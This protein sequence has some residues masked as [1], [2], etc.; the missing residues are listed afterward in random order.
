MEGA[1]TIFPLAYDHPSGLIVY[2]PSGWVSVQ[3]AVK[4]DR[5]PFAKGL[6]AGTVEEK[7]AAFDS[8][9]AYYG[10]YTLD[11]AKR[12]VTH[13]L[14][15]HSWPGRRGLDN[16]RRFQFQGSDR[17]V[18]IPADDGRGGLIDPNKATYK[19]IWER[20]KKQ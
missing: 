13:H 7:A 16:V 8:Y 19:L 6:T 9:F 17:L 12:T 10:T 20:V 3:V 11:P 1:D 18:L 15:D 2:D 4:R 14:V 5:K